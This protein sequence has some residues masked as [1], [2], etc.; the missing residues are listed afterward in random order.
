MSN[1][2]VMTR[3]P[4]D[5]VRILD[6]TTV[7]MGPFCTQILAELGAEVVKVE[8][9]E[10]DTIRHVEPRKSAGMGYMF[11]ALNRGKR[12]IVLDLKQQKGKEA[13]LR[14][15]SEF[16]VLIYNIRP[17]AMRRLGFSYEDVKKINKKIL[18]VGCYGYSQEGP[19]ARKPAYD[20]L[21]QGISGMPW[22][23]SEMGG[24]TK[25]HSS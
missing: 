17:A 8:S 25:I 24:G 10:G 7:V 14:L 18:Y 2:K 9:H 16:D 23:F 19:Y 1:K 13:L 20:D 12:S 11:L 3:G 4:L 6:L 21:I 5:G 22:L 15:I